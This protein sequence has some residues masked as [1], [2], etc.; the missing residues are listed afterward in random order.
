MVKNYLFISREEMIRS[1]QLKNYFTIKVDDRDLNYDRY[2]TSGKKNVSDIND[3]T[4]HN[5]YQ[6]NVNEVKNILLNLD[7]IQRE[8]NV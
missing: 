1:K 6:L 5:T 3:Y 4:S 2:F 8:I 7:F